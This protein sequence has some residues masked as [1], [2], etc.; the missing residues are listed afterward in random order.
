[1][2]TAAGNWTGDVGTVVNFL[3]DDERWAIRHLVVET[4]GFF[5]ERRLLVSPI[6]FR[7]VDWATHVFQVALTKDKIRSGPNVEAD[8]P[9]SRQHE[10]EF[11]QYYGYQHYWG[12]MGVGA[13]GAGYYPGLLGPGQQSGALSDQPKA[14]A[15]T[16]GD[17]HLGVPRRST[18]TTSKGEDTTRSVSSRPS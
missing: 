9:V 12:F 15:S 13:W 10:L 7:G 17:V 2:A 18:D 8:R 5:N 11:Y 4:G 14:S 1:M 6:S 3:F 16:L